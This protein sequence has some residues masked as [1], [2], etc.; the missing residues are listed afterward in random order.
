VVVI[1]VAI[2]DDPFSFYR[3]K[4]SLSSPPPAVH[5]RGEYDR[6]ADVAPEATQ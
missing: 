5:G 3:L 1:V 6:L 2:A 4:A